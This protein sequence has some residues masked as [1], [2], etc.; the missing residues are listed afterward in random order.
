VVSDR[1]RPA[2]IPSDAMHIGIAGPATPSELSAY[3]HPSSRIGLPG[4]GGTPVNILV[5]TLLELGHRVT[6]ATLDPTLR[7][8][9]SARLEG[10]NLTIEIGPYRPR[11]R[12]RDFFAV[13]RQNLSQ[14]LLRQQP[15]AISAHWSYEFA[16]AAV[17]TGIPTLVT[18]RD[19][20]R[21]IFR[22]QPSP[23]RLV[24]WWLHRRVL[25]RADQ[26][27]FN[28]PYTQQ[29][30]GYPRG[31]DGIVLP[32]SIPDRQWHLNDRGVPNPEA[33][34]MVSV[35]NGFS[36]WK[37]VGSL[38]DAFSRIH[39]ERSGARLQLI[40]SAHEPAGAAARWANEKGL[41]AGI[42]FVGPLDYE[43]TLQRIRA[44]DV[45]VHPSLEESF[46]YTLIEAASVGVP[47]IAGIESGAVPWVL[48]EGKSGVLVDVKS[49]KV[50]ASAV[51][52]L[53]D[54]PERWSR[55]RQAAFEGGK[56]RFSSSVVAGRYVEI[57]RDMAHARLA[58]TG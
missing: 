37:N 53:V 57:L 48:G 2:S 50:I 38:I 31:N 23:Y 22:H 20:P 18:V 19:V 32:N 49:P 14:A 44:A 35:N 34:K 26:L 24:R 10:P 29:M 12:A 17:D 39:N 47:V 45:L 6:L 42:E 41:A 4:M 52:A 56:E 5:S 46:G 13:E 7:S 9:Q 21:Q 58:H 54:D 8:D 25:S 51:L 15:E 11:H 3:L 43:Q 28:S 27:A 1:L 36:G 40:G 33:P 16:L 30:L 55:L